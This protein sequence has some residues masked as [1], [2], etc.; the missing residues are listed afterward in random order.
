[1]TLRCEIQCDTCKGFFEP[2]REHSEVQEVLHRPA[3]SAPTERS[4]HFCCAWCLQKWMTEMLAK[5]SPNVRM[6]LVMFD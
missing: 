6:R 4:L 3:M 1:M 5:R 2:T